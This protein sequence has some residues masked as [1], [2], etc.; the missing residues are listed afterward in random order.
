MGRAEVRWSLE[1]TGIWSVVIILA[2]SGGGRGGVD[3]ATDSEGNSSGKS[4]GSEILESAPGSETKRQER[5]SPLP[6]VD[7]FSLA[8]T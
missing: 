5:L 3:A 2:R 7:A 1:T 6:A 8:S 4:R